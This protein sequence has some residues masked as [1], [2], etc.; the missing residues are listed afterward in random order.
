MS[1]PTRRTGDPGCSKMDL[2]VSCLDRCGGESTDKPGFLDKHFRD[3][4]M[5]IILSIK[6]HRSLKEA[7]PSSM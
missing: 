7:R 3:I 6:A 1:T 2:G 4:K 5:M